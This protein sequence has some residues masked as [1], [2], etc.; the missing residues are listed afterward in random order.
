M[1]ERRIQFRAWQRTG[2]GPKDVLGSGR[3]A[4]R[5]RGQAVVHGMD[6]VPGPSQVLAHLQLPHALLWQLQDIASYQ[7]QNPRCMLHA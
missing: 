2:A 3:E 1:T 6:G 7:L 5:H 4:V